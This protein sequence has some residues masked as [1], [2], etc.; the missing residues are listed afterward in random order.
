[1]HCD[2]TYEYVGDSSST[3]TMSMW[4]TLS[5]HVPFRLAIRAITRIFGFPHPR[6]THAR[7]QLRTPAPGGYRPPTITRKVGYAPIR[8]LWVRVGDPYHTHRATRKAMKA[9][10]GRVSCKAKS[11]TTTSVIRLQ[12]LHSNDLSLGSVNC[13]PTTRVAGLRSHSRP[14]TQL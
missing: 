9:E 7:T 8:D 5:V 3:C 12:E 13:I 14:T 11:R 4:E 1:M 2:G 10:S 6:P